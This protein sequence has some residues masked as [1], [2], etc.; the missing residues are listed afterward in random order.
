MQTNAIIVSN[1]RNGPIRVKL[2]HEPG[3]AYI[4]ATQNCDKPKVKQKLSTYPLKEGETAA[5]AIVR[6]IT[7]RAA[8]RYQVESMS[9]DLLQ[10]SLV[11]DIPNPDTCKQMLAQVIGV[12][13]PSVI[14]L[15]EEGESFTADVAGLNFNFAFVGKKL[16]SVNASFWKCAVTPTQAAVLVAIRRYKPEYVDQ[17][18]APFDL[19]QSLLYSARDADLH[20]EA[21]ARLGELGIIVRQQRLRVDPTSPMSLLLGI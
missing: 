19:P 18:N 17:T 4:R 11:L 15:I 14:L 13:N 6:I 5:Q 7:E 3:D 20:E 8:D 10:E 12:F 21:E 1:E 2:E 9:G 16:E